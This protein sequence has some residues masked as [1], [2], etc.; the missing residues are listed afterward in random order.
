[1]LY[2]T[3]KPDPAVLEVNQAPAADLHS[4]LRQN[5]QL[6]ALAQSVGLSPCRLHYN[7]FVTDSGGG[8]QLTLGGPSC[9]ESPFF[10]AP[11]LL[12]RLVRYLLRHPSLSYWFAARYLGGC[13]QSPRP[14]EGLPEA[15]REL[16]VALEQLERMGT[17]LPEQLWSTLH[18]FL[19]DCSGNPHRAELNVEK[20]FNP[21]LP[22]RGCL[23]L[24]E[25]RALRMQTSAERT[26]A[27][28]LL[29]R[30]LTRMLSRSDRVP[31]LT[32]WGEALHDRF[33]LPSQLRADLREVFRD[34]DAA[35]L[36]L[37]AAI[38]HNL[39]SCDERCIG[40][41]E[42]SGYRLDVEQALEFWPLVGDVA[43]QEAGGSRLVDA[44]TERLELRLCAP[45]GAPLSS[46]DWQLLANG[47]RVPLAALSGSEGSC[48]LS[49]VRYR[50]FAPLRGLHPSIRPQSR[51]VLQLGQRG[52]SSVVRATWHPWRPDGAGYP[53]L[54]L[55]EDDAARRRAER[56]VVERLSFEEA[57]AGAPAPASA[58][59]PY[60]LD[61]RRV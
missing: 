50:S 33:A 46:A 36:G 14:D 53:G 13:S 19:A 61:L 11:L 48:L 7:G 23:G 56:F 3:L 5:R 52:S 22:G 45:S 8:G 35:G 12:P 39:L 10:V 41:V 30:S 4:F 6:F 31:E 44:S 58:L 15:F 49:G 16:G 1:V 24:V 28:A 55:D 47:Y 20:L 18:H 40:S 51:I 34:L 60:C 37:G 27:I 2:T 9:D 32:H 43:S 42:L 17:P 57:S 26:T 54:P 59:T 29:L 21:Y 38:E 25:F